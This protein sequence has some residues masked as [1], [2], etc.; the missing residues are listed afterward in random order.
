MNINIIVQKAISLSIL[1]IVI[2]AS[3]S[4]LC[5]G[6]FD[7]ILNDTSFDVIENSDSI[8]DG[9]HFYDESNASIYIVTIESSSNINFT[10]IDYE[11]MMR[12]N[13]S[14]NITGLHFGGC[15]VTNGTIFFG[16]GW[17]GGSE[18]VFVGEL[19]FLH[20]KI[21]E[22][23]NYTY[24]KR[25]YQYYEHNETLDRSWHHTFNLT[26]PA[27]KWHFIFTGLRFDLDQDDVNPHYKVWFN[28]TEEASD[29]KIST[30][31]GGT[32]YALCYPEYDA[33][34]IISKSWMFELMFNGKARFHIENTFLF[35]FIH[36]PYSNGFWSIHW[37]TPEGK[38]DFKMV[39]LNKK[40]Y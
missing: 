38:K 20:M 8:S 17:A 3:F 40:K 30:S 16:L 22:I 11:I 37:D 1:A 29:V 4:Q 18:G 5:Q 33:N 21:G 26:F 24:D 19:R 6:D 28:F 39:M 35:E 34:L 13:G 10:D 14:H 12:A 36:Y 31:E 32:I 27:G 23:I 25:H 15:F 7:N 9:L 2:S